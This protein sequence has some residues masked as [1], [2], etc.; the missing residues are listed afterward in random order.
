MLLFR[1]TTKTYLSQQLLVYMP[2]D[3]PA[4]DPTVQFHTFI[5]INRLDLPAHGSTGSTCPQMY[6]FITMPVHFI[7]SF[8]A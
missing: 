4:Q 8:S 2:I 7:S 3:L 5:Q 1:L 6:L